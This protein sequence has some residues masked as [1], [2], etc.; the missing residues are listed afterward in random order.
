MMRRRQGIAAGGFRRRLTIT[1]AV[2]VGLSAAALGTGTYFVV[3]HNLLA[4]SVDS[5]ITQTRRNLDVARA[6]QSSNA[7]D[8]VDAYRSRG[9]FGTV[10]TRDGRA[11][12]SGPQVSVRTVPPD[13]RAVVARGELGYKRALIGGTHYVVTGAPAAAC[14]Q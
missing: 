3:R 14:S 10:V 5:S 8:L 12:L 13:L 11:Y 6:L 4:D 2:A 9:D 7:N 1:F